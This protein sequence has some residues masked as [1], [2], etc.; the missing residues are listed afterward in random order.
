MQRVSATTAIIALTAVVSAAVILG[1]Y[2][3]DASM[4]AGFIPARLSGVATDF[5]AVPAWLTPLTCTLLH[6]GFLH[7][8]MNMLMLGF[9]GKETERALGAAGIVLLYVVGAF[10]AAFAQ[11]LPDP[12][13]T[14]PMIGASG[15]AS[16]VV[17]AYSLL[18]GRSRAKAIG[19]IPAQA[20]HVVWL[21]VAWTVVNLLSAFAFLGAGVAVA[22]PAH[23]GG[24]LAGLVLAKPLLRWRW[25]KA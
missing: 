13:A 6:G 3:Y 11:W 19:P 2:D 4:R 14:I 7:L 1:H 21:A 18:F 5:A 23:I 8:G 9:T 25:R 15:A 17:G 12:Q 24:F 22:A 20:V 16:A 10:V